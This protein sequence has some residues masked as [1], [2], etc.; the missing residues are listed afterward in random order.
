MHLNNLS[1]D[2]RSDIIAEF[3]SSNQSYYLQ[4][5]FNIIFVDLYEDESGYDVGLN[6]KELTRL[7]TAFAEFVYNYKNEK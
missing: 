2:D 6:A 1:E 7:E 5:A 4:E 3:E